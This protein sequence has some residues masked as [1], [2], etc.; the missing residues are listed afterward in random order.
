MSDKF[1]SI[2]EHQASRK[3][4]ILK[5]FK[6][7][8]ELTKGHMDF[9]D[10]KDKPKSQLVQKKVQ[11]KRGHQTTRWVKNG[12]DPK[13]EKK[14]MGG[15]EEEGEAKSNV[16]EGGVQKQQA[17]PKTSNSEDDGSA[18]QQFNQDRNQGEHSE[19][20]LRSFA[21]QLS[22]EQLQEFIEKNGNIGE[23]MAEVEIAQEELEQRQG[24]EGGEMTDEEG[25]AEVD[26]GAYVSENHEAIMGMLME[27]PNMTASMAVKI[28]QAQN[29]GKSPETH[30]KID[31]A[32]AALDDLKAHA[33]HP[34]AGEGGGESGADSLEGVKEA[35]MNGTDDE[36]FSEDI[37]RML[38]GV[39]LEFDDLYG[40]DGTID[41]ALVDQAMEKFRAEGY[42]FET[43]EDDPDADETYDKEIIG[44]DEDEDENDGS[45]DGDDSDLDAMWDDIHAMAN[46]FDDGEGKWDQ[47]LINRFK[48]AGG[49]V[50]G[51][52]MRDEDG[53]EP[54]DKDEDDEV[55]G[56]D[57]PGMDHD[58]DEEEDPGQDWDDEE[59]EED[60]D[61]EDYRRETGSGNFYDEEEDEEEDEEAYQNAMKEQDG[62]EDEEDDEEA[63]RKASKEQYGED[64]GDDD[65][66]DRDKPEPT[67]GSVAERYH[68]I[69]KDVEDFKFIEAE[70]NKEL[71]RS[72]GE[73]FTSKDLARAQSMALDKLE[74][75][76]RKGGNKK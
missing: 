29:A 26:L 12:E 7:F 36:Q 42:G 50:E 20:E 64:E 3:L 76:R 74:Q 4:N 21:S 54:T 13:A 60:E 23:R 63:S 18:D 59:D 9:G 46:A 48:E 52:M 33:G 72:G 70:T 19:E 2:H 39:G 69:V 37:D 30:A 38:G 44:G 56:S 31:A 67:G 28:H 11:D 51:W 10:K 6:D 8:E 5:G 62:E 49:E 57:R 17:S 41:E 32:Q 40:E 22:D 34:D 27:D 53:N 15:E 65:E 14:P 55:P 47:D 24:G 73:T 45:F 58:G 25:Q 68:A 75:S 61:M 71:K 35:L 1:E 66:E 43:S 16:K